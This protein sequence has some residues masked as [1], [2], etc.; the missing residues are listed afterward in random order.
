M[1]VKR[2]SGSSARLTRR[3]LLALSGGVGA[4]WLA[5]CG[6]GSNPTSPSGTQPAATAAPT[7]AK[8]LGKVTISQP[9]N[10][11]GFSPV[12]IA[13]QKGF[14]KDNGLQTEVVL[15]GS[16]SKAAAAVIGGSAQVGSSS[17]SDPLG[18]IEKGQKILIFATAGA[19][20]TG[21]IV[22]RK[23]V[24]DKLKVD[25]NSPLQQR[26]QALKGLKLSVSTP[27]SGTD[28]VLRYMLTKYGL[29]PERDVQI[30]TTGSVVNSQ[31]AFAQGAAD[32]TSL[33]SPNAEEA[34]IQNGGIALINVATVTEPEL[35]LLHQTLSGGLWATSD[36][37]DKHADQATAVTAAI[38]KALDYIHTNPAEASEAVRLAAWKDLDPKVYQAAWQDQLPIFPKTP[39]VT[40]DGLKALID[41]TALT[42]KAVAKLTPD[43][44]G[45][46]K[47]VDAAQQQRSK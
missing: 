28:T 1:D 40:T 39:A 20:T 22:L 25:A 34:V 16:G 21:L 6:T 29:D 41:Y 37:L 35:S 11:L 33:S 42:D 32:G 44:I 23:P 17:L 30:L 47:F 18:A 27:G 45:T 4:L 5:G 31:A 43:Q 7:Q 46:Q 26:V 15:G 3:R 10:S 36:W 9:S 12:I 2:D 13:D 8:S 38:W 19:G 14:F 24:A